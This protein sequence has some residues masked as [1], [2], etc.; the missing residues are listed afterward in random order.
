MSPLIRFVLLILAVISL[1]GC[2]A[3]SAEESYVSETFPSEPNTATDD[4]PLLRVGGDHKYP[5]FEFINDRGLPDGFN[6]ELLR[7]LSEIM[8]L[9]LSI[10]LTTWTEARRRL[11]EGEVDM[12]AG[13]YRTPQRDALHDFTVPHFIAS[14]GLFVRDGSP[15]RQI[16]D[17]DEATILVH[18]GDLGHDF[19]LQQNLGGSMVAV[20]EWPEVLRALSDGRGDAA[21]FG[22]AQGMKELRERGYRNVHMLETP[23]FERPY[24]M[25]V[26]EG[27]SELLAKL[28]EGLSI[29]KSTGEFDKIYQRW[30]GVLEPTPWW[31]R[32]GARITFIALGSLLFIVALG[33]IWVLALRREVRKKTTQLETALED[34]ESSKRELEFANQT[35]LRFL[36]NVSHELR[37]PLHGVMGM[38]ELLS[39]TELDVAQRSL[40][41]KV[42]DAS[43]Q[44]FRVLSDLLDFSRSVSG[45]LSIEPETF[46]LQELPRW[47]EPTLRNLAEAEGLAFEFSARLPEAEV[48]GDRQ[49]IG[50]VLTNLATNAVKFTREGTVSLELLHENEELRITVSD[51]GPGIAKEDKNKIFDPFVQSGSARSHPAGGLGLGLSIVK[52]LVDEMEGSIEIDSEENHGATFLVSLPLP[53]AT[54]DAPA[55]E[56]TN[57]TR[58][59]P[60]SDLSVLIAEDEAIN[61]LYLATFLS[62]SGA[63]VTQTKNG[64]DALAAASSGQYDVIL[65]DISM[66]KMDGIEAARRIRAWEQ[67]TGAAQTPIVALTAHAHAEQVQECYDAGMTAYLSKPYREY[68]VF[69]VLERVLTEPTG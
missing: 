67:E 49:R 31:S 2:R 64:E 50:Q 59:L 63:K 32:R 1:L 60:V 57:S 62:S 54:S 22:M 69:T 20:P 38:T 53:L 11:R 30:F 52:S 13:M 15:V 25:A 21:V 43:R 23:L 51:T 26:A 7:R 39:K 16:D 40:L 68:E 46:K 19:V 35:K 33:G 17:L 42:D 48:N 18:Q 28:N 14:Y 36:A 24:A 47:L 5:P 6:I 3:G 41:Q 29:L 65:M 9:H 27:D 10:E 58:M 45:R 34:S 55:K 37:T 4:A 61:R 44:L 56:E 12:L 66:P 8:N